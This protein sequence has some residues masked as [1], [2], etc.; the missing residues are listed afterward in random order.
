[1]RVFNTGDLHLGHKVITKY[2]DNFS[3]IEEHDAVILD[4]F[5]KLSKKD[6]KIKKIDIQK[7]FTYQK[8]SKRVSFKLNL[9]DP[10][11]CQ[12]A[13]KEL[14]ALLKQLKEFKVSPAKLWIKT[15]L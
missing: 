6:E 10:K 7:H 12:D 9:T 5:A 14:E 13:I 11:A 8:N 3:S 1:M 4:N 15:V 2:R